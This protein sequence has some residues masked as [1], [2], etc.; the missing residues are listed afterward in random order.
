MNDRIKELI[1]Y[2]SKRLDL[3]STGALLFLL[4]L[5]LYL[6]IRESGYVVEEPQPG[7]PRTFQVKIPL[8]RVIPVEED[9]LPEFIEDF[10]KVDSY[11]LRTN[12]N[13][14]DDEVAMRTIM[15]NVFDIKSVED[16]ERRREELN[17]RYN[18]AERL[19]QQ[20]Q[21]REAREIVDEILA[22]DPAHRTARDLRRRLDAAQGAQADTGS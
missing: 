9:R 1:T 14:E 12:P 5:T 19:Y 8:E 6:Y 3:V 20:Q 18:Q 7:A 2:L 22:E 16:A 21:Y 17:R 4:A 13:I 15:V 10:E 11:F